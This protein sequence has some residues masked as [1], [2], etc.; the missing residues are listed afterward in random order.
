MSTD[1]PAIRPADRP[2]PEALAAYRA[3]AAGVLFYGACARLGLSP[4]HADRYLR[5]GQ[6]HGELAA[7]MAE[8]EA[9]NA[10]PP[11]DWRPVSKRYE[12]ELKQATSQ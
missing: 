6:A 10:A 9:L 4:E 5:I 2:T 11:A 12:L 7:V 3:Q 1:I 8:R